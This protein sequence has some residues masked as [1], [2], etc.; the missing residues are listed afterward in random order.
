MT[1]TFRALILNPDSGRTMFLHD[2]V[3]LEESKMLFA[4]NKTKDCYQAKNHDK[5]FDSVAFDIDCHVENP[6][7]FK[8]GLAELEKKVLLLIEKLK[9]LDL[10]AEMNFTG[11]GYQPIIKT[12]HYAEPDFAEFYKFVQQEFAKEFLL[13]LGLEYDKAASDWERVTRVPGT[14]NSKAGVYCK[15]IYSGGSKK[16]GLEKLKKVFT[17]TQE[18][19]DFPEWIKV[20]EQKQNFSFAKGKNKAPKKCAFLEWSLTN[21]IPKGERQITLLPNATAYFSGDTEKQKQWI[22]TQKANPA[23][24]AS[25]KKPEFNCQ[26]LRTYAKK[27]GKGEICALC[28]IGVRE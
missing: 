4:E 24:F 26:Q 9:E 13:P 27:I 8:I 2:W 10:I 25:W 28:L 18:L 14:F 11:R 12:E 23:C 15:N 5:S 1:N 7:Q 16:I 19:N 6:E 17:G 20:E 21:F 3:T 22:E